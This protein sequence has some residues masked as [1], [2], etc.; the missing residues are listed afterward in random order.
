MGL[1]CSGATNAVFYPRSSSIC[2]ATRLREEKVTVTQ[3]ELRN[4]TDLIDMAG[5]TDRRALKA[6]HSEQ[7]RFGA[8]V[9]A[10]SINATR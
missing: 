7:S 5:S 3:V 9:R 10:E 2:Q 8:G 1:D 6:C 4:S